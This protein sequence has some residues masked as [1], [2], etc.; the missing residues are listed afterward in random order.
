[1]V[2]NPAGPADL[3]RAV[4]ARHEVVIKPAPPRAINLTHRAIVTGNNGALAG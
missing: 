1:L 2:A 4:L 3:E